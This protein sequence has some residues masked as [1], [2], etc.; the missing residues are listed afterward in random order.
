M[1]ATESC[2]QL[3]NNGFD[4]TYLPVNQGSLRFKKARRFYN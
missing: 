4:V 3:S 1:I 2:E